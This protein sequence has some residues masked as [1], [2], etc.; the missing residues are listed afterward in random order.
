MLFKAALFASVV[1][2]VSAH[3]TFQE[4][5][6]NGVDQGNY[7][8]RL[9]ASNSPVT[10]VTTPDLACNVN[11]STSGNLC[12]VSPGDSVTVEMH[13]Q[14]G[15]RSCANEAIGGDHYGPINIYMAKVDD[16]TTAVGADAAWFKINE[17]GMPSDAP[18]YWAT[19]VLNDNCGHFTFTIPTGIAAGQY[20]LRAEV[21]AL[22]VASTVGGAQF[23]MSCFQLNVGG[24]GTTN[25]PTVKIPGA[26]GAQ[27]PGIL[28]NI[29]Q[30]LTAYTIPGPTPYAS[31]SPAVA[32]TPWPTTATWNTAQQPSTVPTAPAGSATAPPPPPPSSTPSGP[33]SAPTS[34]GGS[35]TSTAPG[36][37]Q[38][39]YGQC[40][41]IGWTG[42]TTCA[43]G[44]TCTSSGPYYSQCL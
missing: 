34:S 10:S 8:V 28:I 21:I 24:T 14:P 17:M 4:M 37:V 22:H 19:E 36:A 26:Y 3:A 39:K 25:P 30:T 23:Y 43:S 16:A 6:V 31:T 13:Q 27:D 42:A 18:D 11:P 44:S 2:S 33:T 35:P 12:A 41:G 1:A 38:T 32:N 20:L 5:W 15:D 40:G 9:P 7:C 29:Y